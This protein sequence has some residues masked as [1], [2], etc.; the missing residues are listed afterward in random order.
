RYSSFNSFS[1][2]IAAPIICPLSWII[3]FFISV[4]CVIRGW[5]AGTPCQNRGL[6]GCELL[7]M[8][9]RNI[10]SCFALP[11]NP[12]PIQLRTLEIQKESQF[13]SG[14]AKITDHLC[15]VAI[16]KAG[17]SFFIDDDLI[18]DDEIRNAISD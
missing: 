6:R 16:V 8:K 5:F 1:T 7:S 9:I 4:I 14:N 15:Y 17:D 3:S 13:K 11:Y 12:F 2:S 18:V 10:R